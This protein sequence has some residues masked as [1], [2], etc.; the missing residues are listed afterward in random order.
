MM[1]AWKPSV[2][3]RH[4]SV[5]TQGAHNRHM[6]SLLCATVTGQS[7]GTAVDHQWAHLG[8][9]FAVVAAAVPADVIR[10]DLRYNVR[11]PVRPVLGCCAWWLLEV[12]LCLQAVASLEDAATSEPHVAT[13]CMMLRTCSLWE[14][15]HLGRTALLESDSICP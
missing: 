3:T 11:V 8:H 6:C 14:A 9:V 4:P 10:K 15:C 2:G 12:R 13:Q 7:E 1:C 5:G